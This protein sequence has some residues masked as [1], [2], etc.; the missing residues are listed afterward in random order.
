MNLLTLEQLN[1]L[2]YTLVIALGTGLSMMAFLNRHIH[3][4]AIRQN[5]RLAGTVLFVVLMQL[6]GDSLTLFKSIM[7]AE[8]LF[9]AFGIITLWIPHQDNQRE[10]IDIAFVI[11]LG[12]AAIAILI[13][14]A[15]KDLQFLQLRWIIILQVALIMAYALSVYYKYGRQEDF[16]SFVFNAIGSI[17]LSFM[18][19]TDGLFIMLVFRLGFY[20]ALLK[21]ALKAKT[22]YQRQLD[23]RLNALESDFS[24]TVR[25]E[26]NQRIFYLERTKEKMAEIH[27]TDNLTGALTKKAMYDTLDKMTTA[28][29]K[30][31]F[32]VLMF[33]IDKFKAIND[34][35]GHIVGDKCLKILSQ[36]A[37]K[38]IR[39]HDHFCRYGGDEFLIILPD[40][41][42]KTATV[43]A[44]RFRQN[45]QNTE[46]PKF[47]VS[48]GLATFPT[49]GSGT[50]DL[51]QHADDGLYISKENG[52]NRVSYLDKS[53]KS[54]T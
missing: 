8:S 31:T 6:S 23:D 12:I 28:K 29:D 33:D 42:L 26:V 53:E 39:D 16:G 17:F 20:L 37:R 43:V 35:L 54:T 51:L 49:D 36:I 24:D 32:S 3:V 52:R 41:D 19:T 4:L 13:T 5:M 27:K 46:S 50:K 11:L 9:F 40:A 30:K 47:T 7:F 44:E 2:H 18:F 14:P 38:S 34:T 10:S 48:I 21:Q 22:L 25:K 15:W 45:I 1:M